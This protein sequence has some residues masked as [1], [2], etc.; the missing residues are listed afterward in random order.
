M[1][2]DQEKAWRDKMADQRQDERERQQNP[3]YVASVKAAIVEAIGLGLEDL[4]ACHNL[5]VRPSTFEQWKAADPDFAENC[6]HAFK[7]ATKRLASNAYGRAMMGSER[8]TER[9]LGWRDPDAYGDGDKRRGSGD[10]SL[11]NMTIGEIMDVVSALKAG[12][13]RAKAA[14]AKT[15]DGDFTEVPVDGGGG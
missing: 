4:V 6:A 2:P 12:L 1:V 14:E 8:L 13:E 11:D 15:F 5:Q 7:L 9:V 3:E 10:K